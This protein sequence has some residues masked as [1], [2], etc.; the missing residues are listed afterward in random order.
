MFVK[1]KYFF[2]K[3]LPTIAAEACVLSL[4]SPY[5]HAKPFV[6]VTIE[7]F[8]VHYFTSQLLHHHT[9]SLQKVSLHNWNWT[10]KVGHRSQLMVDHELQK[11]HAHK[12]A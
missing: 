10:T 6:V 1:C 2:S 5:H 4:L 3:H 12:V 8:L 9:T 7:S 11:A